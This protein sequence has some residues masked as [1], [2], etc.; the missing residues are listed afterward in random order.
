MNKVFDDEK[1]QKS[2]KEFLFFREALFLVPIFSIIKFNDWVYFGNFMLNV[3]A[4]YLPLI[5]LIIW[6]KRHKTMLSLLVPGA[7]MLLLVMSNL[8]NGLLQVNF[9][10]NNSGLIDNE[11]VKL[12]SLLSIYGSYLATFLIGVFLLKESRFWK[13]R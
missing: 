12:M 7:L 9:V 10:I 6:R 8:V 3:L 4:H 11:Q 5:I 2:F 13:K 1:K